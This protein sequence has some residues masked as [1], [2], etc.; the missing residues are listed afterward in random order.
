MR[1]ELKGLIVLLFIIFVSTLV[2]FWGLN[3][4][5][6]NWQRSLQ[7]FDS[8]EEIKQLAPEMLKLRD[9]FY[10]KAESFVDWKGKLTSENFRQYFTPHAHKPF[11]KL[12]KE[13]ILDFSRGYILGLVLSDEQ[14]AIRALS[15]LNPMKLDFDPKHE[16]VYGNFY[17]YSLGAT[18]LT[19]KAINL[20]PIY[21][22]ISYYFTHPDDNA[23]LYLTARVLS[24]ISVILIVLIIWSICSL[25]RNKFVAIMSVILCVLNPFILNYGHQIKAHTY[26]VLWILSGLYFYLISFQKEKISL[27]YILSTICIGLSTA[28]VLSNGI[29]VLLFII[30]D[31]ISNKKFNFKKFIVYG[32]TSLFVFLVM[33][34]FLPFRLHQFYL[35]TVAHNVAGYGYGKFNLVNGL[36]FTAECF[37]FGNI[38]ILL[39]AILIG[40]FSGLKS[41]T[42]VEKFLYFVFILFFLFASFFMKH[43]G[44]FTVVVPFFCIISAIGIYDVISSKSITKFFG[45]VYLVV[46]L[47]LSSF[48]TIF[49]EKLFVQKGNLTFAGKWINENIPAEVSVGIPGGWALPG[50]FPAIKFLKYKLINFLQEEKNIS[51]EENKLPEYLIL[52][53]QLSCLGHSSEFKNHYQEIKRWDAPKKFLGISFKNE[54]IPTENVDVQV[55]QLK[56]NQQ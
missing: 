30:V 4:G 52:T 14:H 54:F 12:S 17:L 29:F 53:G 46:V 35:C 36:K 39:P 1:I 41:K 18:L 45:I 50:H 15:N 11:E 7:V 23:K 34:P 40:I 2:H 37:K 5:T 26:G 28:C 56:K 43:P 3:H 25:F 6:P 38:W 42:T 10:T 33:T 49:Y 47:G 16:Y 27:N 48:T 21:R 51:W 31:V 8:P 13:T 20:V 55:F 32:I 19:A 22:D 24:A 44:V 9:K